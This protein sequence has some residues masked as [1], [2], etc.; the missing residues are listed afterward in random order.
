MPIPLHSDNGHGPVGPCE[1]VADLVPVAPHSTGCQE[2]TDRGEG[3]LGLCLCLC[4]GWVACSDDSPRHHA[5]NHYEETDHPVVA[6]PPSLDGTR[7]C[8]A[9]GRAV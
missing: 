9:H 2:C 7:W 5:R 3:W 8:Y 4:C 1:H 6:T